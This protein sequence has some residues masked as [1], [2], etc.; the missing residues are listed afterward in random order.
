[1]LMGILALSA[2]ESRAQSMNL[3]IE[4]TGHP[5]TVS[6]ETHGV[7]LKYGVKA[8][9]D[10]SVF[11]AERDRQNS[12]LCTAAGRN[13]TS[14]AHTVPYAVEI[15]WTKTRLAHSGLPRRAVAGLNGYSATTKPANTGDNWRWDN[16]I[17]GP[18]SAT[19]DRPLLATM[20]LVKVGTEYNVGTNNTLKFAVNPQISVEND[21]ATEGTDS[22]LI[23]K[24]TLLPP[25]LE[26]TT[27]QYWTVA[28]TATGEVWTSRTPT[29]R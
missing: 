18:I 27:V 19:K 17:Q 8:S 15:E 13:D 10:T 23:F 26:T 21:E 11:C 28:A 7:Y 12:T 16:R 9:G 22:H 24:V 3:D 14:D 29:G 4:R 2:A 1:M 20:R 6:T 25:A 5:M